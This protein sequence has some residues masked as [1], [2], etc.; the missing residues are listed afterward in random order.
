KEK[1]WITS[2]SAG[3]GA[4][5]SNYR[6]FT[7]SCTLTPNGLEHVDDI[8]QAVFQY[9]SMIKQDGL[10]E[11]RYLEKQAVLESAFRF[12]EPSRPM[13]L[14]SHLVINMQHYQP[15]DTVYGDYKMAGYD[16]EL[17][18]SLLRY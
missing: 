17:Q 10:D 2:L 15:E 3:G 18:R 11:W 7:V 4:S 9:L 1:G 16:E 6:D 5:G 8:V 13:D 12:Q 14:V